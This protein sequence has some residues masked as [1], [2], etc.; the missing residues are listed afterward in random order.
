MP[1]K[2]SQKSI[3]EEW[4]LRGEHDLQSAK[5]LL[6][7]GGATDTIAILAQQ[8][9]EKYLKGYLLT[10]GWKLQKTHDLEVLVSEAI[11]HD[12]AFEQFLDFARVVSA[13]YLEN[14]Y[15]PGPPVGYPREEI[16][17]VLE[18]TEKFTAKIKEAT[19]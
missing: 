7:Q 17:H 14:R 13:Y 5:L 16:A 4:F 3:S 1:D 15:P 11:T 19:G 8:A 18:Q 10:Q 9:A 6:Q 12:K 2:P